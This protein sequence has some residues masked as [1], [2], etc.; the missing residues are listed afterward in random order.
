MSACTKRLRK[1]HSSYIL[2]TILCCYFESRGICAFSIVRDRRI[3]VGQS[4][5]LLPQHLHRHYLHLTHRNDVRP[6]M[7]MS[8]Y[9]NQ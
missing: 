4:Q 6:I 8:L 1:W 2:F 3:P 5:T 9:S 7:M